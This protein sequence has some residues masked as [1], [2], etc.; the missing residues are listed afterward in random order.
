MKPEKTS[1]PEFFSRHVSG[2]ERFYLN[3]NPKKQPLVVVSGGWENC[4]PDYAIHRA[5]F[6]FYSIE[7]V[8]GGHGRLKLQ[9]RSHELHPGQV[10]SYGPKVTHEIVTDSAKPLV[11]YF[12]N[13][14]GTGARRLLRQCQLAPGQ[15]SQ[16]FPPNDLQTLFDELIRCGQKNSAQSENLCAR[17]LECLALKVAE[18]R[19]PLAGVETL[20]FN[21]YVHCRQH[22][23]HHFQRLKTLKQVADE[24]HINGAY[25]C[26]L[27]RRYGHQSP[28]QFVLR[29]K[30]NRAAELLRQPGALV[31]QVAEQAGFEDPFHFS[32][33][34][35][36]VFGLPPEEFRRLR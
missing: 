2:A 15:I 20:A 28:Y 35:K 24:C 26:R 32:R 10:Y 14:S 31:K 16:I 17:L 3:L 18:S 13:F 9:G 23:Q 29:L 34:F 33:T 22:I 11:K 4:A 27:F 5:T 7:Y 21:T 36:S 19:A 30:M 25:L 1:P 6:P 12:V 8:A